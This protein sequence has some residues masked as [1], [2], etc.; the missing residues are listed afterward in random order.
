MNKK[1]ILIISSIVACIII[2]ILTVIIIVNNSN[3]ED[4]YINISENYD[5]Q[6]GTYEKI[7]NNNLYVIVVYQ[8]KSD[9]KIENLTVIANE[10]DKVVE[11]IKTHSNTRN[12]KKGEKGYFV[13][14]A[15]KI[16]E[17][18]KYT[19]YIE[20]DEQN[21]TLNNDKKLNFKIN[22]NGFVTTTYINDTDKEII[23]EDYTIV[24]KDFGGN[25]VDEI[26]TVPDD[27]KV[28]SHGEMIC[29]GQ[30]DKN[31]NSIDL[32]KSE[33]KVNLKKD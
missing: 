10:K 25:L 3:K 16:K 15:K 27:G 31:I 7:D 9:S 24:L 28:L 29:F 20:L 22:E 6:V 14:K 1:Q 5:K 13:A 8:A 18:N 17:L 21:N 23:V 30:T 11:K 12:L 2:I 4:L 26:T 19:Y 32:T 33:L